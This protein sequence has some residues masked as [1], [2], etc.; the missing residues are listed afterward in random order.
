[1]TIAEPLRRV[2]FPKASSAL[3]V[4][5]PIPSIVL[6]DVVVPLEDGVSEFKLEAVLL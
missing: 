6:D 2:A 3:P 1:M 5:E 4:R